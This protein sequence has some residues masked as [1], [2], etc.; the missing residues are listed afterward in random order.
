MLWFR[1]GGGESELFVD[2][3]QLRELGLISAAE[4][5]VSQPPDATAERL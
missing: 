4:E 3:D 2:H 5:G 1:D